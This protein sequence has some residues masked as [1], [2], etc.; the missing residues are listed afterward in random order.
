MKRIR[1]GMLCLLL[2]GALCAAAESAYA[3]EA[4]ETEGAEVQTEAA[5]GEGAEEQEEAVVEEETAIP[6]AEY[7]ASDYVTLGEYI[8]LEVDQQDPSVTEDD[9]QA[10]ID[11]ALEENAT[12]QEKTEGA[13]DGDY[14]AITYTL[15]CDGEEI[16]GTDGDELELVCGLEEMGTEVDQAITGAKAGDTVTAE[17]VLDDFYEEPYVGKTGVYT[18]QISRVYTYV[19]PELTDDY[20]KENL[21]Y[22]NVEEYRAGL[23]ERMQKDA[24][25]YAR[26]EAGE[27]ALALA[28]QNAAI[29]GYPQDLYDSVYQSIASQYEYFFGEE[30]TSFVSEEDLAESALEEVNYEMVV[31]AIEEKEGLTMTEE[32][33]QEYLANN[34]NSFGESFETPEELA[35]AGG[36]ELRE[37]AQREMVCSWLLDHDQVT[38]LSPEEY[39]AKY[40]DELAPEEEDGPIGE[41]LEVDEEDPELYIS[42]L[43][44]E[45]AEEEGG[46]AAEE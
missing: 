30:Y 27:S 42:D 28:V 36:N 25:E 7:R 3:E 43:E 2:A 9:V 33:F 10:E 6:V 11:A 45:P 21:G 15:T 24:V 41:E 5:E 1:Y 17:V 44:E 34:L 16:D 8:N 22:E 26:Y 40:G 19:S 13:E 29:E 31:K 32:Q 23:T 39:E 12:E 14:V 38:L 37:T 20:V 18:I 46:E 35:E 4:A